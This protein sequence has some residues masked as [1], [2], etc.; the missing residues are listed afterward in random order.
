MNELQWVLFFTVDG[1]LMNCINIKQEIE[2]QERNILLCLI[3]KH[4]RKK[5]S[6]SKMK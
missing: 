4:S 2:T 6:T 1:S 5:Q 3:N